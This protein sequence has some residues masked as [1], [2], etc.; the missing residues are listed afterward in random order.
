MER[1]PSRK[2]IW[3]SLQ[4]C[5]CDPNR[6][7]SE[8]CTKK[9]V[10]CEARLERI[11]REYAYNDLLPKLAPFIH[12]R[13]EAILTWEGGDSHS[14]FTIE[15]GEFTECDVQMTLVPKKEKTK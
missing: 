12:G 11:R 15:D 8:R 4:G 1:K 3:E 13:V 7:R 2:A 10:R 9:W 6:K 14:G 5:R